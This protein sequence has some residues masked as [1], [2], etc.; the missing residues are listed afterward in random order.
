[1]KKKTLICILAA[2]ALI[3]AAAG[4]FL[5]KFAFVDGEIVSK[6]AETLDLRGRNVSAEELE[7]AR[8][9]LPETRIL[10]DVA[11]GGKAFDGDAE[12][13]VTGDF[14][15]EDV[16]AFERLERLLRADVSA[17]CDM[18]AIAGLRYALP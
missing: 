15:A 3:L 5:W 13:I 11:I 17:C 18:N 12:S 4:I 9:A 14:T 7:K 10:W 2:A 1:M 6:S 16:P 8:R